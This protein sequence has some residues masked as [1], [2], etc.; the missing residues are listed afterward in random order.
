MLAICCDLDVQREATRVLAHKLQKA[1]ASKIQ[2][3]QFSRVDQIV[4]PYQAYVSSYVKQA[5]YPDDGTDS[6][7]IGNQNGQCQRMI[8]LL[9]CNQ[10]VLSATFRAGTAIDSRYRNDI[11]A[12]LMV[13]A[14]HAD[15]RTGFADVDIVNWADQIL[16]YATD[17]IARPAPRRYVHRVRG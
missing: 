5:D 15:L 6:R 2:G 7:P 13:M 12:G 16:T 17:S 3:Y 9:Q 10:Q 1:L 8:L 11:A 14:N 4:S